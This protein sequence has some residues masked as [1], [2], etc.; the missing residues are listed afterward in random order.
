M[1]WYRSGTAFRIHLIPWITSC[2]M[3]V[4]HYRH[5]A[6]DLEFIV[7]MLNPHAAHAPHMYNPI[8]PK[9]IKC[10]CFNIQWVPPLLSDTIK[11]WGSS[12]SLV[13][14]W[15]LKSLSQPLITHREGHR[16]YMF[17]FR[18]HQNLHLGM[19]RHQKSELG[20][21]MNYRTT[22]MMTFHLFKSPSNPDILE[23]LNKYMDTSIAL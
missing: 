5:A 15:R 20:P 10:Y 22:T 1:S 9:C 18:A 8:L 17:L 3:L 21:L 2:N 19:H 7:N 12:E 4:A 13:L 23:R 6:N 16:L 11:L 14:Q